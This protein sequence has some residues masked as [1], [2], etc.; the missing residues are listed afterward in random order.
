MNDTVA[1]LR[2]DVDDLSGMLGDVE[3]RLAEVE[4]DADTAPSIAPSMSEAKSG[5]LV[6]K[7]PPHLGIDYEVRG[8]VV[9]LSELL[10][11]K[12]GLEMAEI[13]WGSSVSPAADVEGAEPR[14]ME[15]PHQ[16]LTDRIGELE[17]ELKQ[18]NAKGDEL[19]HELDKLRERFGRAQELNHAAYKRITGN[20]ERA[21]AERDA[22]KQEV[23]L[24]R[25][26]GY[27]TD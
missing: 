20:W 27:D 14:K 6:I 12:T 8:A 5:D 7:L 26:L 3:C 24:L 16:M 17:H 23:A 1:K 11:R 15:V 13:N 2:Q 9:A 18:A 10:A 21:I 22:A 25:S 4:L 19:E